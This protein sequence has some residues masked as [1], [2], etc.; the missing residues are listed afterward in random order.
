[1][2][3][4]GGGMTSGSGAGALGAGVG[5]NVLGG[6]ALNAGGGLI[7]ASEC[8]DDSTSLFCRAMKLFTVAQGALYMLVA[9]LFFYFVVTFLSNGG[10]AKIGSLARS[11]A[12]SGRKASVKGRRQ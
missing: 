4:G 2:G 8:K 10:F 6:G 7:F 1:M 12:S 9:L 5:A 11:A 3:R